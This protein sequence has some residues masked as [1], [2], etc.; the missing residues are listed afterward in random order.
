MRI[1]MV[2]LGLNKIQA[3]SILIGGGTPTY[4]S[5]KQLESFLNNFTSL[6][7]T[8]SCK[9]FS[10]DV[11]PTTIIGTEGMEKL[12]IM[13]AF[14]VD[15]LTIGAQSFDDGILRVMNRRITLKKLSSLS[16][17]LKK[18]DS[19]LIRGLSK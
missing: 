6:V 18:Q 5:P 10:Y 2:K 1:Y 15:R 3:R 17:K 7:Y 4:L 8:K 19:K 13:R 9:Q 14:G 16:T 12:K 11:D